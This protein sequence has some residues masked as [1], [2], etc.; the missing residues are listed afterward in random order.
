M[1]R[2]SERF[3]LY[4]GLP[5]LLL[6]CFSTW[7]LWQ[8]IE[9]LN[10]SLAK[11]KET[12]IGLLNDVRNAVGREELAGRALHQALLERD[13]ARVEAQRSRDD[14]RTAQDEADRQRRVAQQLH[15]QR[16]AELNRMRD[17]LGQI[18]ATDRTPLGM[19]VRLTGSSLLFDFD[20]ADL[21]P[22]DREILSRIA[23]VL[24]ASYGYRVSVFGHT[25][26][27]GDDDYNRDLS[28][29]RARA[30][31][32]YLAEAG[33]PEAVLQARGF[34]KESPRV[35]GQSR[36]ARQLNRRVEIAIIDTIIEYGGAAAEDGQ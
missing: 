8:H 28:N 20:K 7:R 3:A 30:V 5:V 24:L 27:Q 9:T 17:A 2:L 23:G 21:R 29:R 33:I 10:H 6:V 18:A 4:V 15:T 34:G 31:R 22:S 13:A 1:R 16:Q 36:E 32:D 11:A 14:A 25:D 26:D 12:E 19:V 35:P